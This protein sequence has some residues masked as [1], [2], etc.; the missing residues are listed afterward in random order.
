[1]VAP[2]AHFGL[3]IDNPELLQVKLD[4]ATQ[5]KVDHVRERLSFIKHKFAQEDL[6]QI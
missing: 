3:C 2:Q 4:A 5:T 6:T 1:L